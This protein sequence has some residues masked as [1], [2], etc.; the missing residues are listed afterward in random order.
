MG[1]VG[2]GGELCGYVDGVGLLI[3]K[4]E[5]QKGGD[6]GEAAWSCAVEKRMK[7]CKDE[8]GRRDCG[9]FQSLWCVVRGVWCVMRVAVCEW[10]M[11]GQ[12]VDRAG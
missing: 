7:G 1:G 2:E 12:R 9:G 10:G 11:G 8:G 6:G 4:H 3:R 5:D